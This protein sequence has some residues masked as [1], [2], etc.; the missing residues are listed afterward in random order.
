VDVGE[1]RAE[2]SE[3]DELYLRELLDR[4]GYDL[5]RRPHVCELADVPVE[6]HEDADGTGT[7]IRCGHTIP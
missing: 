1:E 4:H 5:D 2:C 3:E 6:G 7:C